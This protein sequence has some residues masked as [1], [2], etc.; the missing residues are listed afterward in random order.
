[1]ASFKGRPQPDRVE[2]PIDRRPLIFVVDIMCRR[3]D[4]VSGRDFRNWA[5]NG[6]GAMSDLSPLSGVKR[7]TS[8]PD[9]YFAF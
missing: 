9:E 5:R 3:G 2:L 1:V 6:H 8:A 4:R 7:K